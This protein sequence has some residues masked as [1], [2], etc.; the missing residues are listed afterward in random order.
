MPNSQA[1]WGIRVPREVLCAPKLHR[2]VG[3]IPVT[4]PCGEGAQGPEEL[5]EQRPA[6]PL[7]QQTFLSVHSGPGP[8][9]PL[10]TQKWIRPRPC[11][12][13]TA[14]SPRSLAWG[15]IMCGTRV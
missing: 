7:A 13:D 12:G 4:Q 8:G 11:P 6:L 3:S 5:P 1:W 9:R 10:G 15:H 2:H 14:V